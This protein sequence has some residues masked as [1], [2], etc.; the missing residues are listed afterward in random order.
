MQERLHKEIHEEAPVNILKGNVIK[1]GVHMEL[2]ELRAIAFS[3]KD[4]LL[5]LQQRE[6]EKTGITSLKVGYNNVYGYYLEVTHVHKE[7]VPQDWIRKQTLTTAERYITPELKTYEEKILGAE[8]KIASIETKLFETL[9]QDLRDYIQPIQTNAAL[10]ARLDVFCGFAQLA[11]QWNYNRPVVNEGY[12]IDIEEGR[13][14]VIE[15]QLPAGVDYVS[16]SVYSHN[17]SIQIMMITGPNMSGKSALLCLTALIVLLAQ[18][19]SMCRP[20]RRNSAW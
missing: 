17:E 4:Y 15:Q 11:Q 20:R 5:Q 13:H 8:E 7:K 1:S 16:N 3:G 14:A 18:I 19:G 10:L 9:L 6:S 2:D 12:A